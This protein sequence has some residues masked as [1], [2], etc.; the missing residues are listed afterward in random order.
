L[1][2]L[3]QL[4]FITSLGIGLVKY[5]DFIFSGDIVL[6]MLPIVATI[7]TCVIF[8]FDFKLRY[9]GEPFMILISASIINKFFFNNGSKQSQ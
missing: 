9:Y 2:L 8:Y 3:V 6:L 1:T 4:A 5:R 7:T